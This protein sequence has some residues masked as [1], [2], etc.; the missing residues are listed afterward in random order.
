M[1]YIKYSY[2][3]DEIKGESHENI[4]SRKYKKNMLVL[5]HKT[6]INLILKTKK[7]V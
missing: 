5:T 3:D 6:N 1:K 4:T 2:V 7:K